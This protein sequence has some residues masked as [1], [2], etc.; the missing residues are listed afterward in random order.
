VTVYLYPAD[1]VSGAPS[2]TAETWRL[3]ANGIIGGKTSTRPLGGRTGVWPG[4]PATTV[5]VS[6]STITIA[7]H[8]GVLD[9]E[10]PADAGP[11]TYAVD[12]AETRTLTAASATDQRV[13]SIFVK[14]DDPAEGDGSSTPACDGELRDGHGRAG[15]GRLRG[16]AGGPPNVPPAR[17]RSR[18]SPSRS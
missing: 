6:G 4:T 1:A 13:D 5:T 14:V 8:G 10:T 2:Y 7:A 18:R 16:A 3:L 11:Y 12:P 15:R 9:L 17:S